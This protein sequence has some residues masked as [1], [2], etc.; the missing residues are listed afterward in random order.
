MITPTDS[1][2]FITTPGGTSPPVQ[3]E[4][5]PH[6]TRTR[7]HRRRCQLRRFPHP[8]DLGTVIWDALNG[9][10]ALGVLEYE[11]ANHGDRVAVFDLDCADGI[12]VI[13]VT[14]YVNGHTDEMPE[15]RS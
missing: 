12:D 10:V 8:H 7:H 15:L 9:S 14:N 4:G 5:D 3:P 13:R 1:G 2:N 11:T 6:G